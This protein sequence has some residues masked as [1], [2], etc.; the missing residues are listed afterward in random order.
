MQVTA[1]IKV[2]GSDEKEVRQ[3]MGGLQDVATL[4]ENSKAEA[5][6]V[7]LLLSK[8]KE[9]PGLVKTALNFL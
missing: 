6:D 3:I 2:T 7:I 4:I 1:K 5:S 9:D 8:V